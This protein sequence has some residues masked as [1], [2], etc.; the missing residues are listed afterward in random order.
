LE[1]AREQG[2]SIKDDIWRLLA[3]AKHAQWQVDAEARAMQRKALRYALDLEQLQQQPSGQPTAV[4][5]QNGGFRG[6]TTKVW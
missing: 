3:S 2:D 5:Q 1:A 4:K 6:G